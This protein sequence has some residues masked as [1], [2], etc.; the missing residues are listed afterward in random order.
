MEIELVEELSDA[1]MARYMPALEANPRC[2]RLRCGKQNSLC[3]YSFAR[4][5]A[6]HE[7]IVEREAVTKTARTNNGA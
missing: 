5:E 2:P 4:C 3:A 1:E 7:N 6:R